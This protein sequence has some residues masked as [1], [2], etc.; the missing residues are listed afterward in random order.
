M[1]V[2]LRVGI[3][4]AAPSDDFVERGVALRGPW[5]VYEGVILGLDDP[6]PSAPSFEIVLP[7]QFGRVKLPDGRQL[8]RLG[9]YTLALDVDLPPS[10]EALGVEL[11]Y[12]WGSSALRCRVFGDGAP[13][14]VNHELGSP[15]ADPTAARS[16]QRWGVVPLPPGRRMHCLLAL[17]NFEGSPGMRDAPRLGE[18]HRLE[19]KRLADLALDMGLAGVLLAFAVVHL[20]L[21]LVRPKQRRPSTMPMA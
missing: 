2:A 12:V 1:L 8:P 11:K 10:R 20:V 21:S 14:D 13:R 17:A 7:V 3:V 4:A 16:L 5:Q 18:F 6:L 9:A 15:S 19:A